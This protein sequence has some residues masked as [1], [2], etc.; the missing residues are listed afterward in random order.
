MI[1]G[2]GRPP[3][4]DCSVILEGERI[5]A[6]GRKGEVEVPRD[7]EIIDASGGTLLPGFIDAHTHFLWMGI[8]MVRFVDMSSARSLSEALIQVESRLRETPKGEWV[9]GRG[10]DESKW[11]E[12]RY[13]TKE[14]IDPFSPNH[15]VMLT[16]VDGHLVTLNSKALELA[17]ITRDTPDPPGGKIDR[18]PAGEPTGIL[19]DASHLVERVIPPPSMEIALEG[20]RMACDLALSLGCTGIHDAGLDSFGLEAY[21]TALEKGILKVRAYLMVRGETAKAAEGLSLRTGFGSDFLR[22]GSVKLIMDGSLGARTA[23]LFEPYQDDP[24]TKG[25]LV[26]RPEDLEEEARRAHRKGFQVAIHAIG[27]RGIEHSINIIERILRESPRRDHRH[28]IEHC[29]VMTTNQIERLRQLGIIASMQ[30]N[31]VG[32]W[33]GPGGMYEARLGAERLRMNNPYRALLDEGIHVAFGSDCMP[34]NPIYGLWSALNHPVK[35]S[36]IGLVEAVRCYT[37]EAAYASFMEDLTGSIEP[38]KLADI[39]ILDEDL[40]SIM[41]DRVRDVKVRMT[42]VN[43]KILYSK[44]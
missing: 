9:L 4:R 29:E 43:G 2:T 20:L 35:E 13:I 38:G 11:P 14:D 39:V 33:S 12:R 3:V 8:G 34:F 15:P 18:D 36:R 23:A 27:D 10:W 7:A 17:G 32:E 21:Q 5:V 25:L 40:T 37:L 28:R 19:R 41:P 16:R 44:D 42:I 30:P 6:S 1:D 31:F 24:S 22:L 26:T